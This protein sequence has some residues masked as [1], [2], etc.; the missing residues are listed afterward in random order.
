MLIK[1]VF[2]HYSQEPVQVADKFSLRFQIP[3]FSKFGFYI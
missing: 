1:N 3:V 2:K